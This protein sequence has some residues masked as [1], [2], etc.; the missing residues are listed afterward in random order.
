MIE[1]KHALVLF[2]KCPEPGLTKTRSMEANG[3]TLTAEE[4]AQLYKA[5][6]LATAN[7]GLQA[8]YRC[9]QA[10]PSR[11]IPGISSIARSTPFPV[12]KWSR[13]ACQS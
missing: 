13:Y 1:K 5:M 11:E 3:G 12:N 2:T 10:L 8:L 4:A 9:G 6:V 7:V